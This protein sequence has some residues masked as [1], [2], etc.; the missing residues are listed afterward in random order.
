MARG[1]AFEA[2]GHRGFPTARALPHARTALPSPELSIVVPAWNESP[3]IRESLLR[4][5]RYLEELPVSYE[6]ILGDSGSTDG[7]LEAALSLDLPH[8]RAVREE[9][10]GKG[11]ILTMSLRQA[12]GRIIGF[13]DADLEIPEST[14]GR[15]LERIQGGAD[16]A[17][18]SKAHADDERAAHRRGLTWAFN[19]LVRALFGTPFGDHQAGCKLFKASVLHPL[20]THVESSGWLWD[21][22]VLVGIHREQGTVV[23]LPSPLSTELRASRVTWLGLLGSLQELACLRM[24]ALS[25][26]TRLRGARIAQNLSQGD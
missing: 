4:L 6:L 13:I 19:A 15:L 11:R 14:L 8:F 16:V 21:T 22:E 24:R 10:P 1:A 20:L 17:I 5:S 2:L 23:E 9:K 3:T 7:T 25:P 18:A 26:D 12:R